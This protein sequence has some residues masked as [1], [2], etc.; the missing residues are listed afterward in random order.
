MKL[1]NPIISEGKEYQNISFRLSVSELIKNEVA[2]NLVLSTSPYS[3]NFE[4]LNGQDMSFIIQNNKP[5][6]TV[7]ETEF[8]SEIKTAVE[9]FLKTKGL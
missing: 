1:T 9:K 3:D 7:A 6:I 2:T 8:I 4:V 5:N